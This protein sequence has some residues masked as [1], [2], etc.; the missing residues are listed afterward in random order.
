[1]KKEIIKKPEL[2]LYRIKKMQAGG[3]VAKSYSPGAKAG[4]AVGVA[5]TAGPAAGKAA[6]KNML[7]NSPA[8]GAAKSIGKKPFVDMSAAYRKNARAGQS[9]LNNTSTFT[10]AGSMQSGGVVDPKFK[11]NEEAVKYYAEEAR[12]KRE[13]YKQ[14]AIKDTAAYSQKADSM[15]TV[16]SREADERKKA[17]SMQSGG[18]VR[19]T[20]YKAQSGTTLGNTAVMNR[21]AA[22]MAKSK[23]TWGTDYSARAAA[24]KAAAVR[25]GSEFSAER[26]RDTIGAGLRNDALRKSVQ[27]GGV[28]TNPLA[29]GQAGTAPTGVMPSGNRGNMYKTSVKYRQ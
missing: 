20:P 22:T 10:P 9:A 16:Y 5:K 18:M 13:E 23:A 29:I 6:A 14:K 28:A 8:I 1:M 17:G 24:G 11:S 25:S 27:T 4:F 3:N 26:K 7:K 21:R 15:R 12:K 19:E 2:G